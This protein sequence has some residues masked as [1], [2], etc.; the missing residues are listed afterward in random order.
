MRMTGKNLAG[1]L[2]FFCGLAGVAMAQSME[3]GGLPAKT[4]VAVRSK[5]DPAPPVAATDVQMK[6]AGKPVQ[7][8]ALSPAL[9][10]GKGIELAFVVDDSLR[11]NVAN[12]FN[13]IKAFFR[14]LPPGVDVFVGYM[15]NGHVVAETQGFTNDREALVKALRIP[16]GVPGGNASPYF[17]VSDLV[18]NWPAKRDG[19]ARLLF[20]VTNG[21]DNYTGDNPLNQDSPYVD[22]AIK[23][24]QK[25]GVLVYSLY[26]ADQGVGGG[27]ASFSGQGYLQKTSQ[28]TGGVAY[29][30]GSFNP[31]SFA[32]YLSQF[33]GELLRIFELDFMAHSSGL[34]PIK[35]TTDVKG[36]KLGAPDQV[37][38]GEPE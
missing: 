31:V 2:V 37:Y 23:D 5:A 7:V 18:K 1:Y 29:Y 11:G 27:R 26:F 3:S 17:C 12:Q 10:A 38:V 30:Q 33:N 35:V 24:A 21:V 13:D 4:Y 16:M 9:K 28:E 19:K 14:A 6:E 34:H 8:T 36:V 22:D 20:M 32:P 25:A 15:Q